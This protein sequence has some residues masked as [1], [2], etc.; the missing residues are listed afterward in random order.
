MFAVLKR[1]HPRQNERHL[2]ISSADPVQ[3]H[4]GVKGY[5]DSFHYD[6]NLDCVWTFEA[7]H[8]YETSVEFSYF[9]VGFYQP[10][11]SLSQRFLV[12]FSLRIVTAVY[13]M[14]WN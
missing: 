10:L 3:P 9:E 14:F 12:L 6:N 13:M 7:P 8:G 1:P 4:L 11:L 5:G 2:S